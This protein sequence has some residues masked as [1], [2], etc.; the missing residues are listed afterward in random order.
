MWGWKQRREDVVVIRLKARDDGT[1]LAI[2]KGYDDSGGPVVAF[3]V[4]YDMVLALMAAD[5]TIQ[6]GFWKVD[7]PWTPGANS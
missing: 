3:G 5:S 7:K 6:G 4:G 1:I 2:I